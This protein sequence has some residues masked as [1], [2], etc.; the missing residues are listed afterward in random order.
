MKITSSATVVLY[1]READYLH[2]KVAV[3][4]P[5]PPCPKCG[6]TDEGILVSINPD[7]RDT[8]DEP[9]AFI[10]PCGHVMGRM[11]CHRINIHEKQEYP[12]EE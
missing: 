4:T 3:A 12:K 9:S 7:I 5:V 8:E 2:I 11:E 1:N 10:Y 6:N